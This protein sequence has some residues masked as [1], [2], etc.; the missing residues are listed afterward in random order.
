MSYELLMMKYPQL[1]IKEKAMPRGLFGLYFDNEIHINKMLGKYD[2]HCT[3]AEEIGHFETTYGDI[4]DQST[5]RNRQLEA[6]AR[7]W[8]YN[9]IVSLDKI[10]ECYLNG[11]TTLRDMC[12]HLEITPVFLKTSI[13]FYIAK[14]GGSKQHGEYIVMFDP[15][16]VIKNN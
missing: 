6:I 3:L 15:L 8:A 5:V 2:K 13:D 4:T 16:N 10:I 11:H 7:R 12:I 1:V 9:K 14:F